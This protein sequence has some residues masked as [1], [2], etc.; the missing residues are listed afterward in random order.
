MNCLLKSRSLLK[1][2]GTALLLISCQEKERENTEG[3]NQT[4]QIKE[5]GN[6]VDGLLLKARLIDP[7]KKLVRVVW[8][9]VSDKPFRITLTARFLQDAEKPVQWPY[10]DTKMQSRYPAG[11]FDGFVSLNTTTHE[12]SKKWSLDE[13]LIKEQKPL[14]K[15]PAPIDLEKLVYLEPGRQVDVLFNLNSLFEGLP[16]KNAESVNVWFSYGCN[17]GDL[18]RV[19]YKTAWW[20]GRVKSNKIKLSRE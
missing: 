7:Q 14:I 4:L 17:G 10:F 16:D 3:K 5:N 18:K 11:F 2:L 9:N 1:I 15:H 12:S 6:A 13:I 19:G 20:E 8:K